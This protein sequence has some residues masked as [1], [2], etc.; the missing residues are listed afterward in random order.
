MSDDAVQNV[1]LD[2]LEKAIEQH[3]DGC[4]E[5]RKEV[6]SRLRRLEIVVWGIAAM[7]AAE[8]GGLATA[9]GWIP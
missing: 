1:R 6:Y 2:R 9:L 7:L 4:R 8:I 5:H 3:E